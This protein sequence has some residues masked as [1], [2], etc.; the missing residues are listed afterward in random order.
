MPILTVGAGKD[1]ATLAAAIGASAAGDTIQVDAGTYVDDFATIT[2][3]LT[4]QGI[5]GMAKLLAVGAP[6]NG[7]AI[8]TINAD[9]TLEHIEFAGAAVPDGNGAGIRYEGGHLAID[10]CWFHDN[11]NGL[12]SAPAPGGTI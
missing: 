3:A 8:L 4:I 2:H 1:F 5:G 6:P 7:K 12:L 10:Q 9:V 11:E